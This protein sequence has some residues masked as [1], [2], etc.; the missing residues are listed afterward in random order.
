MLFSRKQIFNRSRSEETM[1]EDE[2]SCFERHPRKRGSAFRTLAIDNY[3]R[4]SLTKVKLP[5]V[6]NETMKN[7]FNI[8]IIGKGKAD[9]NVEGFNYAV[10]RMC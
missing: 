5:G 4:L 3:S 8:A 2:S 9:N 6:K 7:V 1:N 10:N